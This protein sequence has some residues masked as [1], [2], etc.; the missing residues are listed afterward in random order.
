MI[1]IEALSEKPP[2]SRA[3]FDQ[4]YRCFKN[5]FLKD[6]ENVAVGKIKR[7]DIQEHFDRLS[8]SRRLEPSSIRHI[9]KAVRQFFEWC[10]LDL[11]CI[12][13]NPVHDIKIKA[14]KG[15]RARRAAEGEEIRLIFS[16]MKYERH[17]FAFQ[18]MLHTGMRPE[19]ICGMP[20]EYDYQSGT[21]KMEQTVNRYHEV[22]PVGKTAAATRE[23]ILSAFALADIEAQK[24][25]LRLKGIC[26]AWLFPNAYGRALT[27]LH[28]S[29]IWRKY[30]RSVGSDL[31]LYEL[32]HTAGSIMDA[33]LNTQELKGQ[34]GHTEA[35]TT[36]ETY[37]RQLEQKRDTIKAKLDNAFKD[38]HSR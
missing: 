3:S 29:S 15:T 32:R 28:L 21:Y 17:R 1:K 5:H 2:V 33:A 26:S 23:V 14:E 18:L 25:Y 36:H 20:A 16:A 31:T 10:R 22:R 27:P 35:M 9:R 34:L 24:E 7:R 6:F 8:A 37:I 38:Y 11:E 19:E 12:R 4:Y 13:E 30:A